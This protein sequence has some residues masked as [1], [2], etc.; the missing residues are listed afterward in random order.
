MWERGTRG[1]REVEEVVPA[2]TPLPP[3]REDGGQVGPSVALSTTRGPRP[4]P[5]SWRG[6]ALRQS[7]V[8]RPLG[9]GK[10]TAGSS[11]ELGVRMADHPTFP[12]QPRAP[13]RHAVVP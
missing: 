11:E 5:A 7:L 3:I 1:G 13:A 10:L 6:V 9:R 2:K 4:S 12:S 8:P